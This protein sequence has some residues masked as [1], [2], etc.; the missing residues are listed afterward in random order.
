MT[1]WW[2]VG[3][4]A[5]ILLELV[6][7]GGILVFLGA[8]ALVVAGG[9]W[10]GLIDG[11]IP[12]FTT[13]FVTSLVLILTLRGVIQKYA[14]GDE[15]WHNTDEDAEAMETVVTVTE[16][17][18]PGEDGRIMYRGTTWPA[19]CYDRTIEAGSEAKLVFRENTAWVVEPVTGDPVDGPP[20]S[21]P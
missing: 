19:R 17:I 1:I 7:P 12:A 6:V 14:G 4:A 5:L 21:A 11:L 3:G 13:W 15:E 8:G 16:T 10:L 9:L 2:L 20:S 18:R